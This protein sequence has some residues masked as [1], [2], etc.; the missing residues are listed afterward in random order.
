MRE[1]SFSSEERQNDIESILKE[2]KQKIATQQIVFT[3]ILLAILIIIGLWI[4]KNIL[5]T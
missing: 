3:V 5:Y 4:G 2:R 1:F